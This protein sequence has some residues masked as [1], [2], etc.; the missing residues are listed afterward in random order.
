M[1]NRQSEQDTFHFRYEG[2]LF[3]ERGENGNIDE[4]SAAWAE[5]HYHS[6]IW[7]PYVD[8]ISERLQKTQ[9]ECSG[10]V[11]TIL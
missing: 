3:K 10:H 5:P 8:G 2:F 6:R 7:Q 9:K 11:S 1:S 4:K